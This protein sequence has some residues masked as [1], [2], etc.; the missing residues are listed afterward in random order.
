K[1]E[2]FIN[3]F[4]KM[5]NILSIF[6]TNFDSIKY[7]KKIVFMNVKL[8]YQ[9]NERSM[10]I[11]NNK[12]K[13]CKLNKSYFTSF[14]PFLSELKNNENSNKFYSFLF[15]TSNV[16]RNFIQDFFLYLNHSNNNFDLININYF[17]K[18]INKI[19]N[20]NDTVF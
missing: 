6:Y 1:F 11:E 8:N 2:I 18:Y 7:I 3:I 19:I 4:L 14:K 20:N 10:I 5:K 12:I 17:V 15:K 16:N 13:F 9:K